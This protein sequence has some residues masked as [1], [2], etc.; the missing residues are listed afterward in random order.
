[1]LA[2]AMALREE[3]AYVRR[4]ARVSARA[5]TPSPTDTENETEAQPA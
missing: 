3:D 1:M 4:Q 2:T 5:T